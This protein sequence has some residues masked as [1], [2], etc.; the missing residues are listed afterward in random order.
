MVT[1]NKNNFNLNQDFA[2]GLRCALQAK[3]ILQSSTTSNNTDKT[4][5]K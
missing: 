4:E 1:D 5:N 3:N 2:I